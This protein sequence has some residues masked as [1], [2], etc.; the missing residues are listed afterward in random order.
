MNPIR[1]PALAQLLTAKLVYHGSP[2]DF[3]EFSLDWAG[4]T[5]GNSFGWGIYCSENKKAASFYSRLTGGKGLGKLYKVQIPDGDVYLDWEVPISK[6]A[7]RIRKA[8]EQ[9]PHYQESDERARTGG[10]LSGAQLTGREYYGG[11][12]HYQKKSQKE[13][14]LYLLSLG[15]KGVRYES[16]GI[17]NYVIFDPKDAK[18]KGQVKNPAAN[19]ALARVLA[20]DEEYRGEHGAPD[21]SNGSPLWDVRG[22]YPKDFYES[23]A[24]QY[25]GAHQDGDADCIA[26]MF[27]CKGRRDQMVTVYRAVPKSV[28]GNSTAIR[29]GDWVALTR[30]YAKDHGLSALNG[31]FKI[32]SKLVHARDLFT[33]GNSIQEWG[34]DPQ[35][36]TPRAE[37]DPEWER[38]PGKTPKAPVTSALHFRDLPDADQVAEVLDLLPDRELV[39]QKDVVDLLNQA[40]LKL[41]A[42]QLAALPEKEFGDVIFQYTTHETELPHISSDLQD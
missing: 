25:Y 1:Y 26:I 27:R 35:P 12:T 4:E 6:Q 31:E 5:Q 23:P 13:V 28:K 24:L 21:K 14:S 29:P 18:I 34:Y 39:R 37:R 8:L 41:A 22:A 30:V 42:E 33:D 40:G 20:A 3:S 16:D 32:V 19:S 36:I 38:W 11:M 10:F 2:R 7:P 9:T 17:V 15:I